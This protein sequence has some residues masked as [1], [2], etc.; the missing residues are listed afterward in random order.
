MTKCHMWHWCI[1]E[2]Y[3]YRTHSN[4]FTYIRTYTLVKWRERC[5]KPP[6]MRLH[7]MHERGIHI[8]TYTVHTKVDRWIH[9]STIHSHACTCVLAESNTNVCCCLTTDNHRRAYE[10]EQ[11]RA[12]HCTVQA[13]KWTFS[14]AAHMHALH[15]T[16]H[17]SKNMYSN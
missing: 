4:T 15:S 16:I 1:E 6:L 11:S 13:G 3:M 7:R 2:R 8:H 12:H 17:H 10:Q 14:P 5:R 9:A